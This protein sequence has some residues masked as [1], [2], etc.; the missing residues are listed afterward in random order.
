MC[1]LIMLPCLVCIGLEVR[2][3]AVTMLLARLRI[4]LLMAF[5]LSG[6][7]CLFHHHGS[8]ISNELGNVEVDYLACLKASW[9]YMIDKIIDVN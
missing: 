4:F 9:L 7:A 2:T 6:A 3:I 5:S 1:Y 8:L